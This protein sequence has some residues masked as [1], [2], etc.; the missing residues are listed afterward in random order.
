MKV[1]A[2]IP[3][4]GGIDSTHLQCIMELG[5]TEARVAAVY[6]VPYI[7]QARSILAT[8]H[9]KDS[10]VI[11]FIDHDMIFKPEDVMQVAEEAY[12]RSAVVGAAYCTRS[13]KGP[14]VCAFT[15]ELPLT[16]YEGGSV[17]TATGLGCGFMAIATSALEL[18]VLELK[19]E[20]SETCIGAPAYPFFACEINEGAWWGE[21]LSFCRRCQKLGIGLFLDSRIRVGHK[22][23]YVYY[24]ENASLSVP[25]LPTL[26]LGAKK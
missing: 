13:Q 11:V 1:T 25:T 14:L 2:C 6:N 21:D 7:D 4:F 5:E 8:K 9:M 16:F 12:A 15:E 3:Y 17:V 22:G 19:L 10:D 24:L 26:Q 20:T 23:S 18:I